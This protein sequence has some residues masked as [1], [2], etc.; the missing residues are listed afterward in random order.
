VVPWE[1]YIVV[2][3]LLAQKAML[4]LDH[5]RASD[6]LDDAGQFLESTNNTTHLL[7]AL[8]MPVPSILEERTG[9]IIPTSL[10]P[11]L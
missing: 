4:N 9:Q 5:Y 6:H 8:T 10:M 11:F 1:R 3:I 7:P 2:K